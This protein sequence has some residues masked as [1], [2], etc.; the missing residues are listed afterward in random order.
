MW[1][2]KRQLVDDH[3]YVALKMHISANT[4]GQR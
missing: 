1:M 3:R 4:Q 2:N